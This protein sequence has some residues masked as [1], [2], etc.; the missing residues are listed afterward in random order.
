MVRVEMAQRSSRAPGDLGTKSAFTM[1]SEYITICQIIMK[2]SFVIPYILI[3]PSSS[4]AATSTRHHA[5][6]QAVQR[7]FIVDDERSRD[8]NIALLDIVLKYANA[9]QAK[10]HSTTHSDRLRVRCAATAYHKGSLLSPTLRL[11]RPPTTP[12]PTA[13]SQPPAAYARSKTV[14]DVTLS[15][16]VGAS[17]R[18]S[19]GPGRSPIYQ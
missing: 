15:S 6:N 8:K 12:T 14:K 7:P 9:E 18:P 11:A 5:V 13:V 10:S 17:A 4:T 16:C 3:S 19:R 2:T 1:I